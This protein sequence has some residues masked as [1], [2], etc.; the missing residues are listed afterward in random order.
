MI[1]RAP[2]NIEVM[3]K[4]SDPSLKFVKGQVFPDEVKSSLSEARAF[5]LDRHFKINNLTQFGLNNLKQ[6]RLCIS[7]ECNEMQS[8][9]DMDEYEAASDQKESFRMQSCDKTLV[10]LEELIVEDCPNVKSIISCSSSE[11]TDFFLPRLRK[12]SLLF[13]PELSSISNGVCIGRNLQMMGL[14]YCPK[15]LSLSPAELSSKK[16]MEIRGESKWWEALQWSEAEWGQP[17]P[18]HKFNKIF[19]PVVE[20][21]GILAQLTTYELPSFNRE[22]D[23]GDDI[24][25]SSLWH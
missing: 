7:G 11:P 12:L 24:L 19:Y 25:L 5:F 15:V 2:S 8:I 6:L 3:F 16:L 21:R 20:N 14:Y 17:D 22:I 9:V 1:S 13:V 4:E 18:S 23:S 10:N